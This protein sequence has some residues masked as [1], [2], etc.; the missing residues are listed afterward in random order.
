ML[1]A[2]AHNCLLRL[3]AALQ[4]GSYNSVLHPGHLNTKSSNAAIT[5]GAVSTFVFLLTP[6]HLILQVSALNVLPSG[7]YLSAERSSDV[8]HSPDGT[9]TCGFYNISPNSSTFSIWFSKVGARILSVLCTPG[10]QR[11]S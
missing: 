5:M 9:F 7:S 3:D 1:L 2:A 8:L 4:A 10:D 11:S 6:I